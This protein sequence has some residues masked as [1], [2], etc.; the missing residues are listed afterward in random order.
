[1]RKV[2]LGLSG[3]VDSAVAAELLKRDYEV[4]GLYLS[5]GRPEGERKARL[6]AERA[7]IPLAVRDMRR[8]MEARVCAPFEAAYR[9]GETPNPCVL[10]NPEVK[11][12]L[13]CDEADARGIPLIATGHYARR[14]AEGLAMGRPANDQS[15][16]LCR[17]YPSQAE[18]LLLPLGELEKAEVRALASELGLPSAAAPDSMEICFIPDND[19]AAWL[20]ARGEAVP[21]EFIFE[22]RAVGV[23]GGIE[24]FTLGQGSGLGIA[25]GKK[26][27]VTGIDPVT[28]SVTLGENEALYKTRFPVRD[29]R[30]LCPPEGRVFT[31]GVRV[32]HTRAEPVPCRVELGENGA[33]L[34]W[35]DTPVRA[36]APGQA[37][38]FYRGERLL[39]GGFIA[40][41]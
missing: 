38:A 2:L 10:C 11:L 25:L 31:A 35:C 22:G 24:N 41:E 29:C 6:A 15:Y 16:M 3:G 37:A 39:G 20:R 33:A 28:R 21:G 19:Y 5:D 13:L 26:V 1:M 4:T 12:R 7:G 27:F 30:W 8:E 23:H 32:R 40:R 34:V 18:R 36:P 17:L 9:R 14:T